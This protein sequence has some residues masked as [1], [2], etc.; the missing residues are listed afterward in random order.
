MKVELPCFC[1]DKD[2]PNK[3]R[4]EQNEH[5]VVV[6]HVSGKGLI[7]QSSASR[8]RRFAKEILRIFPSDWS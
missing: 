6:D 8:L 1:G 7:I 4:I 2:C 3:I 5:Q